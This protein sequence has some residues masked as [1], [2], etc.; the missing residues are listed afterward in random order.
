MGFA[1][2]RASIRSS[3]NSAAPAR[4]TTC[5]LSGSQVIPL[6]RIMLTTTGRS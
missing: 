4:H 3:L 2:H 6:I 5:W 1:A